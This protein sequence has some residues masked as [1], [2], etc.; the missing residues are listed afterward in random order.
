[1][2]IIKSIKSKLSKKTIY[3]VTR[4]KAIYDDNGIRLDNIIDNVVEL[5]DIENDTETP[6]A[7]RDADTLGGLY[8][9]DDISEMKL[10]IEEMKKMILQSN[11]STSSF[12]I[13][14]DG[15][16]KLDYEEE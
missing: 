5:D 8:S 4:T 16:A 6:D 11:A 10:A 1:M 14:E 2:G 13:N 12:T 9:A 3:P 15:T 7:P